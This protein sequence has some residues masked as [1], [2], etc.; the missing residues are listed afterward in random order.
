[1]SNPNEL[2]L[3]HLRLDLSAFIRMYDEYIRISPETRDK[4][5]YGY[6]TE[7]SP[8]YGMGERL[9]NIIGWIRESIAE[10]EASDE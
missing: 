9:L 4:D 1:M 3:A 6:G 10:L 5:T 8:G 2:R 7:K